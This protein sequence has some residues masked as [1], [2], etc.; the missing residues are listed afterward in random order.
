MDSKSAH[1]RSITLISTTSG[2]SVWC[3]REYIPPGEVWDIAAAAQ[4][5]NTDKI[6]IE[7]PELLG[8]NKR[9]QKWWMKKAPNTEMLGGERMKVLETGVGAIPHHKSTILE[10]FNNLWK[11]TPSISSSKLSSH[12]NAMPNLILKDED[13]A[14]AKFTPSVE[15][16]SG[17]SVCRGCAFSDP[18]RGNHHDKEVCRLAKSG[19]ATTSLFDLGTQPGGGSLNPL[20]G[21]SLQRARFVHE[22]A[23]GMMLAEDVLDPV[24]SSR[25][26]VV[27]T[28]VSKSRPTSQKH[29]RKRVWG[30]LSCCTKSNNECECDCDHQEQG[31]Q[32][33]AGVQTLINMGSEESLV[34]ITFANKPTSLPDLFKV[35]DEHTTSEFERLYK[36]KNTFENSTTTH[37]RDNNMAKRTNTPTK[38]V[39]GAISSA[40]P[41]TAPDLFR[42][43]DEHE[44]FE[45][46]HEHEYAYAKDFENT[47]TRDL[48]ENTVIRKNT[49]LKLAIANSGSSAVP[50]P[51]F[52]LNRVQS[53]IPSEFRPGEGQNSFANRL[54]AIKLSRRA[55]EVS[56]ADTFE[57]VWAGTTRVQHAGG[58]STTESEMEDSFVEVGTRVS[59]IK[60]LQA[61]PAA[62]GSHVRY[63]G[64]ALQDAM[65]TKLPKLTEEETDRGLRSASKVDI[66]SIVRPVRTTHSTPKTDVSTTRKS[67]H[68]TI[69]SSATP[70]VE[71]KLETVPGSWPA[72]D[73]EW[74]VDDEEFAES[75]REKPSP[76]KDLKKR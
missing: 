13:M 12:E 64:L 8:R 38:A 63:L 73:E 1:D 54:E 2:R 50:A 43:A 70:S 62:K 55:A 47:K 35:G 11:P 15:P 42:F 37:S 30:W 29:R 52:V 21:P 65:D 40:P 60:A 32:A 61:S 53:S 75:V 44:T 9:L 45:V 58:V 20:A 76:S 49:E 27:P 28:N 68:L 3:P 57:N 23:K 67:A 51:A 36:Y 56:G 34:N 69:P 72:D 6:D 31:N 19:S 17:P 48:R 25:T 39:S 18:S 10:R 14:T 74:S 24:A 7:R 71:S 5:L 26:K 22:R 4:I 46:D 66:S 16:S 41:A 33:S 59:D